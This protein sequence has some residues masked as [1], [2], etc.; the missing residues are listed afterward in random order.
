[1]YS[2]VDCLILHIYRC[3][4]RWLTVDIFPGY[5]CTCVSKL[6]FLLCYKSIISHMLMSTDDFQNDNSRWK[7]C[8]QCPYYWDTASCGHPPLLSPLIWSFHCIHLICLK[9]K[10][11]AASLGQCHATVEGRILR[12]W[13]MVLI[14]ITN[15]LIW[16][17]SKLRNLGNMK[18]LETTCTYRINASWTRFHMHVHS[19]RKLYIMCSHRWG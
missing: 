3:P 12:H 10:L 19:T 7:S 6:L 18:H 8:I 14:Y 2:S 11:H 15:N 5:Q 1:M 17:Y 4:N 16:G 13:I 9:S